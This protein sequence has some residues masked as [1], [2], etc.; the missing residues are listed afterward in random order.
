M[1]G[2]RIKDIVAANHVPTTIPEADILEG[3]ERYFRARYWNHV[4]PHLVREDHV[5]F[6]AAEM[7]AGLWPHTSEEVDTALVFGAWEDPYLEQ[8][9]DGYVFLDGG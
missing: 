6:A 1:D 7:Y 9:E 5:G 2:Y 8:V 4:R 3:R